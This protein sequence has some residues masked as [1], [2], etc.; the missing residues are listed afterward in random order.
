VSDH[1]IPDSS[2]LSPTV[3]R[4]V[5]R[6]C[7]AFEA[8][9]REGQRPSLEEWLRGVAPTARKLLL[10]ELLRVDLAYRRLATE[11]PTT[12]EYVAIFPG[13]AALIDEVF[14]E[15]APTI[16]QPVSGSPFRR[17]QPPAEA[18]NSPAG[19]PALPSVPGYEILAELGRA[20]MGV[21]Y[22]ARQLD[23]PRLVALKMI[24]DGALA[25]AEQ[26]IR[27][28]IEIEAIAR[29]EH[30]NL[31]HIYEVGR[32][33]DLPYFSMEL[34]EGGS[35]DRKPS[36]GLELSPRA[37]AE[38]VRTI[39]LAVQYA[40]EK[41][42]IHRDLKPSN[43][44]LAEDGRPLVADFGLAKVLD[45]ELQPSASRE[46]LGTANYMSPEAALG[47]AREARA[48]ADVYS[49]GAILYEIL[50]GRPP[51]RG[52]NWQHTVQQVIVDEPE[53]PSRLREGVPAELEAVCLKCLEKNSTQRYES[54][55]ALADDLQCYLDDRPMT[56]R[57]MTEWEQ[58]CRWARRPAMSYSRSPA[59]ALSAWC[60]G[61]VNL[62]STG[63]S[64]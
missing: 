22:K 40:H 37:A 23:P 43:I 47:K 26:R 52:A 50:T 34:A 30:P 46:I 58:Q 21:V 28:R 33:G 25:G 19:T 49:L 44:L 5:D 39:A 15:G 12:V 35:L 18:D 62:V 31:V 54:A 14:R 63:P 9:W 57:P 59:G 53:P 27:F 8:A 24:R 51:F 4:E 13:D 1:F 38:L 48:P 36:D 42:V 29:F 17:E 60:T 55:R 32:H 16:P 3:A 61:R 64:F 56:V 45:G 11:A 41:Q 10:R 6:A 2:T 7:D 20:G